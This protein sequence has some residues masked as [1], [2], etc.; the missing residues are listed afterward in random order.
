MCVCA[1]MCVC[2]CVLAREK[3]LQ[4][5]SLVTV[6]TCLGAAQTST[7]HHNSTHTHSA[8]NRKQNPHKRLIIN[9]H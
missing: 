6:S 2:V 3:Y 8:V 9:L 4:Q 5:Q 1:S 7:E